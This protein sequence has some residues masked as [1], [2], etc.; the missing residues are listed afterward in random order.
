MIL[1]GLAAHFALT[2]VRFQRDLAVRHWFGKG[3]QSTPKPEAQRDELVK[4]IPILHNT[5][6]IDVS[7][8]Q[9]VEAVRMRL[10]NATD[11]DTKRQ[12]LLD[13]IDR[14]VYGNDR[15]VL[16][17][18]VPVNQPRVGNRTPRC[19]PQARTDHLAR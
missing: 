8:R 19:A 4:R 17:G 14:V 5:H 9:Y 2:S 1:L 15:V 16:Y 11:F 12:F 18:S 6:M 3:R 13:H 10:E 7:V